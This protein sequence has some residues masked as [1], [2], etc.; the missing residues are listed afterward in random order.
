MLIN[1]NIKIGPITNLYEDSKYSCA[2]NIFN[3]FDVNGT[4]VSHG[5]VRI[6]SI[7]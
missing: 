3:R 7:L 2:L 5:F 1:Y 4:E 6:K